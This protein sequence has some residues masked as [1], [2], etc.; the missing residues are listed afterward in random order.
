MIKDYS[1]KD[2]VKYLKKDGPV[3]EKVMGAFSKLADV[4]IIFSPIL[5]GTAFLPALTLLAA[6]ERIV[7]LAKTV[8]DYISSRKEPPYIQRTEKIKAAYALICYTSYF[9]ALQNELPANVINKL[10][11]M[12][13][14]KRDL[15]E[16]AKSYPAM[17]APS[18]DINSNVYY[19]DHATSLSDIKESLQNEYEVISLGLLK[20]IVDASIFDVKDPKDKIQMNELEDLFQAL[21]KKA[22]AIYEAQYLMLAVQFNDFAYFAQL[23]NF[24]GIQNAVNKNGIAIQNLS[25][26]ATKI[27]VGLSNLNSIVKS[28]STNY[29]AIQAQDIVDDLR[30]KYNASIEEPIIDDKEINS[31]TE[32]NIL[33]FPKIVDAFI[34]QSYK[35]LLYKRDEISL[36]DVSIWRKQTTRN[37]LNRFFIKYLYSPD[38]IDYPLVI[39]GH[40]GS[41]KSLLTKVLSAQLMSDS[42]TVIRIPLREVDADAAID[43]LVE[44]QVK[45]LTNRPLPAGYGGFAAQFKEKPL[46]IILDGFD[47]L[48]QAK[49]D[50]FSSYIEKTRIFQQD[51]KSMG[52]PVRIILTS[53]ITLIDKAHIPENATILRLLEF[54]AHQRQEWID[55]WNRTNARY[56][57]DAKVNLFMLPQVDERKKGS[58]LELAEQPLLLLMLA[59]YDSDANELAHSSNIKR[60]ELYDNLIRRF[61]RRERRRYVPYFGDK[62]RQEQEAIIDNEMKRL[63]VVAIGMYNRRDVVILSDQLERDLDFYGARRADGSPKSRNLKESESV[64]GGFF[65]FIHKSTAQDMDAS[66]DGSVSAFEFLHNT[67]GEFLAADFILR[68]AVSEVKEMYINR[69]FNL[70][71]AINNKISNPDSFNDG[72]FACLM[73]VPLYSRPVIIEMLQDH[74]S[75]ALQ[76]CDVDI[77]HDDFIDNLK[78]IVMNHLKMVLCTRQSPSVM[79]GGILSD[80]DIPLIGHLSIYTLN[81][82]NLASVLCPDGFEFNEDEYRNA[83]AGELNSKPWDKLALL[84]RSWFAP[85]DLADL[86]VVL[87]AHRVSES[88]VVITC[89]NVFETRKYAQPIDVLL[90]ISSTLADNLLTGL[91]GLRAQRFVEITK[92][93]GRDIRRLLKSENP[94]VYFSY[95]IGEIRRRIN[96]LYSMRE[97]RSAFCRNINNVNALIREVVKDEELAKVNYDTFFSLIDTLECC[98]HRNVIFSTTRM[99]IIEQL[100]RVLAR[101]ELYLEKGLARSVYVGGARLIKLLAESLGIIGNYAQGRGGYYHNNV[102]GIE[103]SETVFRTMLLSAELTK[104]D[105]T[106]LHMNDLTSALHVALDNLSAFMPEMDPIEKT[107]R[108]SPFFASKNLSILLETNPTLLSQAILI[109]IRDKSINSVL[110]PET[111]ERFFSGCLRHLRRFGVQGFG[112]DATTNAIRI[113]KIIGWEMFLDEII[114]VM[115]QQLSAY[116]ADSY[117]ADINLYL[118]FFSNLIDVMPE[119][120]ADGGFDARLFFANTR[121]LR[122]EYENVL[123]LI[124]V[125]RFFFEKVNAEMYRKE[126]RESDSFIDMMFIE[127]VDSLNVQLDKLTIAQLDDLV[128][129]A[130]FA[131]NSNIRNLVQTAI[132]HLPAWM[133]KTDI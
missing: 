28:I 17:R 66:S 8:L 70:T 91:T 59:I 12:Y 10:K 65:F 88:R 118:K 115:R 53:R 100:S 45:K 34:P 5:L 58:L 111:L 87:K 33:M 131:D 47:E 80:R 98:F 101:N 26:I 9:D 92:M 121:M 6:K 35:C 94:D 103:W 122:I 102:L 105:E 4:A 16:G 21:P 23:Q 116:H 69:K 76:R 113:A 55:I 49:G 81:L 95:L 18:H 108:I 42:Y 133:Q 106:M 50:V 38:G 114:K 2:I 39:L 130:K 41:G 62:T 89:N 11:L 82:V 7:G 22:I 126:I 97:A 15:V 24:N 63:G 93:K 3:D 85:K 25:E 75:N 44:D 129:Y 27:D 132:S 127:A 57:L 48:L 52:R 74:A 124:N 56:F 29:A 30:Q 112:F 14:E 61:I 128:W 51:Q 19:A 71:E 46:T 90:C 109:V 83:E 120:V 125:A 67:F 77:A 60:T 1:F 104:G 79:Q 73:F 110:T 37:D 117:A 13:E 84:W 54:D 31:G 43:V 123:D 119:V 32:K 64:L 86:S 40:P 20:L 107:D 96:S 68:Y 99:I 72:W 36:E 78:F